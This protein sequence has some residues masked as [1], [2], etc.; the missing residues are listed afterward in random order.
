MPLTKKGRKIK[1]AMQE[2]YG[3]TEGERVFY[4]SRNKGTISGVDAMAVA[5]ADGRMWTRS[6]QL[7]DASIFDTDTMR[8]TSDGYLVGDARVARIGT[9]RYRG[10]EV[11]LPDKESVILYRPE[12]EVFAHDAMHSMANK[13]ITLTH[14]KR[15]VDPRSWM[16]VARGFSGS[17]V[18]RDG[19]FVRV[20][21]MLTDA[22][23]IDAVVKDGVRELS[24][25]YTTDIDWT[26]GQ[27]PSGEAY[28][29][30]QRSIRA[31]HHAFVPAARGGRSLRFGDQERG[32]GERTCPSCGGRASGFAMTCP[33]CGYEL[34]P[35][36]VA[37][38]GTGNSNTEDAE[39]T[40]C[41][42]CGGSM[43]L[44]D[45]KYVCDDCGKTAMKD[46]D[47]PDDDQDGDDDEDFSGEGGGA[48]ENHPKNRRF[49]RQTDAY[50]E[51]RFYDRDVSQEERKNLA[52]KGQALPGGGF[53]IKSRGDLRN[54]IRAFGRAKN[55][56]ATKRLIKRR[57]KELGAEED[58]PDDWKSSSTASEDAM[59]FTGMYDGVSVAFADERSQQ[60]VDRHIAKLHKVIR[61]AKQKDDDDA[62]AKVEEEQEREKK[63]RGYKDKMA[64]KD[65]EIAALKQKL[66]EATVSDAELDRRGA[67]RLA[68][69]DAARN[70]LPPQFV[71]QGKS[72]ADIKRAVVATR[73]GDEV[74]KDWGDVQ[75]DGAFHAF[76]SGAPVGDAA[77][78]RGAWGM[79][80]GMSQGMANLGNHMPGGNLNPTALKDK[81][82]EESIKAT[83]DAWKERRKVSYAS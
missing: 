62:D 57:A 17:D 12:G 72:L 44:K 7:N 75:V 54:A 78:R 22:E 36:Y 3:E 27:T 65:G 40:K 19:E 63:E 31:N 20:P 80:D 39:M 76:A 55:P 53:P 13:P 25:G 81:A 37:P 52:E 46:W 18:V 1:S 68:V 15:M 14:P 24:V 32:Q 58:L 70:F 21:L 47:E 8:R 10:Y 49:E 61:D 74:V 60:I 30:V 83:N 77:P 66:A 79:A 82:Y 33:S 2:Q 56:A 42:D 6:C 64:A 29:G 16:R 43:S 67:E 73:L 51:A 26:P 35:L 48:S 41:K 28:D 9:Q 5:D 45:G 38:G 50:P 69:Q 59:P 23:A 71:Y 11:G 34:D 4:A